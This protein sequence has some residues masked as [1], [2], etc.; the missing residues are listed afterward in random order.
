MTE[1]T[2]GQRTAQDI[3]EV[4]QVIIGERQARD[5]GWWSLL[6]GFYHP[7]AQI[8]T[9]W[10]K[11][12]IPE[13]I[14]LSKTMAAKDPSGHRLGQ[15]AIRINGDR[16]VAEVPMTVEFRGAL[17]G[18]EADLTVYIRFLHRIERRDGV[19]RYLSSNA[20]FE[21]DTLV[22]VLPGT[23]LELDTETLAGYR[24]SYRML[25]LWLIEHGHPVGNDRYGIDR[26]DQVDALYR[27]VYGW[28]GLTLD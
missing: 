23:T 21:R 18:V 4:S 17:N 16:A 3:V 5:R 10:F 11:G 20:V 12:S 19:W 15:P 26:P 28:A 24:P 8:Q 25:S 7:E 14:E 27:D 6:P 9:S 2:S 1:A 22:P 13:Y